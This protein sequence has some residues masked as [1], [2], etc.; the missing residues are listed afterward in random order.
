M[1][2]SWLLCRMV[3]EKQVGHKNYIKAK[4]EMDMS[5]L[6]LVMAMLHCGEEGLILQWREGFDAG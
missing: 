4:M 3:E 6:T 5:F 1:R 2:I